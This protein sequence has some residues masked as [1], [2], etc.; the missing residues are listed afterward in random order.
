MALFLLHCNIS[1]LLLLFFPGYRTNSSKKWW[2][3]L[4]RDCYQVNLKS[5]SHNL[6]LDECYREPY[7]DPWTQLKIVR[8]REIYLQKDT[9][10]LLINGII[11]T[12]PFYLHHSRSWATKGPSSYQFAFKSLPTIL[13][14]FDTLSRNSPCFAS[15]A[16]C[17]GLFL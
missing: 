8:V 3:L 6:S 10:C 5:L 11:Y 4:F 15:F 14:Y 12:M 2:K 13:L 9:Q 7:S 1:L 17:L 16:L